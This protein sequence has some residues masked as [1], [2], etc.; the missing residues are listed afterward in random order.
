MVKQIKTVAKQNVDKKDEMIGN[1]QAELKKLKAAMES[2]GVPLGDQV[3][4]RSIPSIYKL[5]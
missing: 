3:G 1:L 2:G 4:H 5:S